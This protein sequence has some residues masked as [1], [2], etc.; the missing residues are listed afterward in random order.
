MIIS[1]YIMVVCFMYYGMLSGLELERFRVLFLCV[2]M[3]FY[4][5]ADHCYEKR[6]REF[7]A[8]ITELEKRVSELEEIINYGER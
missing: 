1:L 8:K 2:G 4:F 3:A 5:V 7:K 6:V